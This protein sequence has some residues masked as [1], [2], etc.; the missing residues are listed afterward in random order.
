MMYINS[1]RVQ[2]PPNYIAGLVGRIDELAALN[3]V[4]E[5]LQENDKFKKTINSTFYPIL[6]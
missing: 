2:A 1:S 6:Q 5:G 3:S 4:S